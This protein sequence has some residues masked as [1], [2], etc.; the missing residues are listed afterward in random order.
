MVGIPQVAVHVQNRA[1]AVNSSQQN[2]RSWG[3]RNDAEGKVEAVGPSEGKKLT[4]EEVE[5]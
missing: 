2:K 5:E 4:E 1:M 3:K